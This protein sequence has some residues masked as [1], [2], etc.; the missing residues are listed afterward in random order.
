MVMSGDHHIPAASFPGKKAGFQR[1]GGWV[2]LRPCQDVSEPTKI[3]SPSQDSNPG[4]FIL[5][6]QQSHNMKIQHSSQ[7]KPVT[8]A[9]FILFTSARILRCLLSSHCRLLIFKANSMDQLQSKVITYISLYIKQ[10]HGLRLIP[11]FR[12]VCDLLWLT[13]AKQA[14]V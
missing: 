14:H 3:P 8:G 7:H 1:I 11:K 2:I 10:L 5:Q 6:N 12:K 13:E 9:I 4:S